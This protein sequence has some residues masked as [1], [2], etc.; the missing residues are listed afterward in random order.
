MEDVDFIKDWR[1]FNELLVKGKKLSNINSIDPL[2]DSAFSQD[3]DI[4]WFKQKVGE[5]TE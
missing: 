4:T 3:R 5:S 1:G 2:K